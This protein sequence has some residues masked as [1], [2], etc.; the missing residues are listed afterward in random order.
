MNQNEKL[1]RAKKLLDRETKGTPAYERAKEN[2][3]A[4]EATLDT[5]GKK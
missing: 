4:L 1:T 2:V 5:K 3:Q